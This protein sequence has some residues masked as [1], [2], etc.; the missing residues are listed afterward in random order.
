M[1]PAFQGGLGP[2][3]FLGPKG[4]R[5]GHDDPTTPEVV[6]NFHVVREL[7]D[8]HVTFL[9]KAPWGL[10]R[11]LH[12]KMGGLPCLPWFTGR[13]FGDDEANLVKHHPEKKGSGC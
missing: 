12:L 11:G 10:R 13:K 3:F 6:T 4:P 1:C 2:E 5:L 8:P 7:K 9:R